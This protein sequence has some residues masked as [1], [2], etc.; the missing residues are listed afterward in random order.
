[1]PPEEKDPAVLWDMWEAARQISKLILETDE[2]IFPDARLVRFSV[3]RLVLLLGEAAARVS[4][5]YR[6][7]HPELPWAAMQQARNQVAHTDGKKGAGQLYR[8]CREKIVPLSALLGA[9]VPRPPQD[10]TAREL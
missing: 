5:T 4:S 1:M 2:A 3:E 10:E 9:L 7:Q 8:L 6:S